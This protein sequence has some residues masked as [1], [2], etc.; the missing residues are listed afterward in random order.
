MKISW[1]EGAILIIG[2]TIGSGII[3]LPAGMAMAAKT[4]GWWLVFIGGA[5]NLL[6]LLAIIYTQHYWPDQS[7]I[8]YGARLYGKIISRLMAVLFII[9]FMFEASVVIRVFTDFV[10]DTILEETPNYVLILVFFVAIF[11][12]CNSGY[13]TIKNVNLLFFVIKSF[14]LFLVV[15]FVINKWDFQNLKPYIHPEIKLTKAIFES[16][17]SYAGF[18]IMLYFAKDFKDL[19]NGIKAAIFSVFFVSFTYVGVCLVGLLVFG[20]ETL[21][22]MSYPSF[23]IIKIMNIGNVFYRLDSFLLAGW[24]TA[25]FTVVGLA[26][27]TALLIIRKAFGLKDYRFLT[28]PVLL[29]VYFWALAPQNV[30]EVKEDSTVLSYWG[31][32]LEHIFPF[33]L[34]AL[35]LIKQRKAG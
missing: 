34:L 7:F 20:A 18:G 1:G 30:G 5:I 9:Y 16:I 8:D 14:L 22:R 2:A 23:E 26:I 25:I 17:L 28:A 4:S 6:S 32:F 3:S 15:F 12:F 13:E 24:M 35:T 29:L 10:S 21:T 27:F 11:Y 33:L 19:K 31:L